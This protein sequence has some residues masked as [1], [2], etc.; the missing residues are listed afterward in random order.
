MKYKLG[1]RPVPGAPLCRKPILAV[2]IL[3]L[4]L[5]G[6]DLLGQQPRIAVEVKT[7]FFSSGLRQP[8]FIGHTTSDSVR[9]LDAETPHLVCCEMA[10]CGLEPRLE[11]LQPFAGSQVRRTDAV[12]LNNSGPFP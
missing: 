10:A 4:I 6:G 7:T 12:I 11:F 9:Q 3:A 5:L 2:A 1:S 8:P